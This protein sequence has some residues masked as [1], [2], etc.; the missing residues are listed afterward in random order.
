MAG[1]NSRFFRMRW[2]FFGSRLVS[3]ALAAVLIVAALIPVAIAQ[4]RRANAPPPAPLQAALRALIEG[5]YDDVARLT[6]PLDQQDPN[7]AAVNAR[8]LVARGEYDRAETLLRPVAQ[9]AP[10]SEAA[11]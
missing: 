10:A 1:R 11:P 9:R 7:V 6:A 3:Y 5:K 8:A 4:S 2:P